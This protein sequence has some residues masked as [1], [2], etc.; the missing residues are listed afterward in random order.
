MRSRAATL[1]IATGALAAGGFTLQTWVTPAWAVVRARQPALRLD[2][3]AVAAGQGVTLALL[4]GF[5]ALVADGTWIRMYTL[6]EQRDLPAVETLAHLVTVL[7]P[8]PVYFWLNSARILAYDF[9]AWRI[10]AAG[11]YDDV[12][13][14]VQRRV[15]H[16]QARAGLRFLASGR[17]FHP[18]SPEL[19]IE[20]ANIE[21][22]RL[23][24][25]DAAAESYRRA[26]SLPGAPYYVARMHAE[27]LRRAGRKAEALAWLVRLHP[28][29]PVADDGAAAGLVLSR[30]RDL[31]K[32]LAVPP[33]RA[34]RPPP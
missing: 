32:D 19:W 10:E 6:W 2:S 5:R 14:E 28:T 4:G 1:L 3:R 16:E 25:L 7:D 9:P 18:Q 23:V 34:D 20:Q 26:W 13:A 31:E 22:N 12:P 33:E 30:I 24:D 27:C 8:R 17:E 11:G 29:L 15:R 21:L